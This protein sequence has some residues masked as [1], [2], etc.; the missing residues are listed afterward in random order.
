MSVS[1]DHVSLPRLD[2]LPLGEERSPRVVRALGEGK[3]EVDGALV[4]LLA[5]NNVGR[6]PFRGIEVTE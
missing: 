1:C 2:S 5:S 4:D 6:L 3:G